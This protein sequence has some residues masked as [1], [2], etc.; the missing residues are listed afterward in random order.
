M[1]CVNYKDTDQPLHMPSL[2]SAFDDC[3]IDSIII[4]ILA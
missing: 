4:Y 3:D 1:S 2:I